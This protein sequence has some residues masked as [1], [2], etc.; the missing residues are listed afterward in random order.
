MRGG[1]FAAEET[2]RHECLVA[3]ETS[4]VSMFGVYDMERDTLVGVFAAQ[5]N[6]VSLLAFLK[7]V[8][9]RY[10][11][12]EVL[13]VVLDNAGYHRKAQVLEY[14]AGHKIKFYWTPTNASRLNRIECHFT[15]MKKF[16]L[17]NTEDRSHAE[18]QA[19]IELCLSRRNH[20]RDISLQNW[21]SYKRTHR[22][23]A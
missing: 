12:K 16:T 23:V 20:Q 4:R 5:K 3:G 19:A 8:R 7:W 21:K 11:S 17:D 9:R 10:S 1:P 13:H 18:Q 2:Y 6:W 22:K 15:A 14:A